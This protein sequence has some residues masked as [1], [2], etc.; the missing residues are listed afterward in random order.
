MR[1]LFIMA[2]AVIAMASCGNK[3]NQNENGVD[4]TKNA[5]TTEITTASAEASADSITNALDEQLKANDGKNVEST[6]T[7]AKAIYDRL[8]KEGKT[9]EAKAYA[10]KLKAYYEKKKTDIE[11][12]A[13]GNTT[14]N[15]LVNGI[16]NLPENAESG[17]ESVKDAAE[18]DA[19]EIA[20]EAKTAAKEAKDAAEK[21]AKEAKDNAEKAVKDAKNNAKEKTDKAVSDA[22]Q[23]TRNAAN[24]AVND[25]L[26]KAFGN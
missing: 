11:K 23:K 18:S 6:M 4:S 8:V 19:E 16:V 24:K 12:V 7:A 21:K 2:G 13:N 9:E 14:I 17:A 1:K 15:D 26:N 3:T 5:D 25:A 10:S 20:N 22:K